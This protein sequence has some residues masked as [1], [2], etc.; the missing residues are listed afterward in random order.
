MLAPRDHRC[1]NFLSHRVV[2]STICG[3]RLLPCHRQE[4]A[5]RV[6]GSPFDTHASTLDP[7][8]DRVVIVGG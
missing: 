3:L 2:F 7:W 5:L 6:C 1:S 4:S 8:L